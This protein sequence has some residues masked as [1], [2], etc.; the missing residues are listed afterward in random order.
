MGVH[1]PATDPLQRSN[2]LNLALLRG[3]LTMKYP[4]LILAVG[5]AVYRRGARRQAF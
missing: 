5:I 1:R 4:L 2:R 3:R